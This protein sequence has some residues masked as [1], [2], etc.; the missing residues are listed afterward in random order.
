MDRSTPSLR[1]ESLMPPGR[2]IT[3]IW[4]A[5]CPVDRAFIRLIVGDVAMLAE[6]PS[7]WTFLRTAIEFR[8]PQ[9]AVF[10]FQGI[11]LAPTVEEYTTLI[12]RPMPIQSILVPN[13][14]PVIQSQLLALLAYVAQFYS[15]HS[16][17]IHR[18]RTAPIPRVPPAVAS[19]TESFAQG[20]M[21]IEFQ[22]IREERDRLCC[23]LVDTRA[24]L[25]DHRELQRELA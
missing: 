15:Q 3:R 14:F 17:P 2:E 11:E 20:A 25:V 5:F 4:R 24:D 21:R 22:S 16:V 9:L 19:E 6:S 18:P 1:L 8:D 23:E 12:Q 7:D 10:N 13:Q